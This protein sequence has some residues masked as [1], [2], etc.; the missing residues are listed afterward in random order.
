M[1]SDN[2]HDIGRLLFLA[3]IVNSKNSMILIIVTENT[4]NRL[5]GETD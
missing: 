1:I 3:V 2:Y 5:I 4:V